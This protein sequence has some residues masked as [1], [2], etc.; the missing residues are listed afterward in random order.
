[1]KLF[2]A[3]DAQSLNFDKSTFAKL[4]VSLKKK[5]DEFKFVDMDKLCIP[6]VHLP[7]IDIDPFKDKIHSIAQGTPPFDLKLS[8]L[9]AYPDLIQGRMIWIGVQNTKELRELQSRL[10]AL[11][12]PESEQEYKPTLPLVRMRNHHNVAD[13]LSPYKSTKFPVLNAK[14]VVLYEMVSGGA[15]PTIKRLLE[16]SLTG[17]LLPAHN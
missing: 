10:E 3:L 16:F 11:F 12:Y 14:I 8:G 13:A 7:E 15:Y 5:T 1:M 17:E 9:S 6:L 4:R 2:L